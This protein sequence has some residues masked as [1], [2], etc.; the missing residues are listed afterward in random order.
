MFELLTIVIF[1]WLLV[2]AI[3]LAF[4]L[5]WGVA[6]I[7]AS[8]L[9]DLAFPV[10]IVCFIFV[11]AIALLVPVIMISIAAGILKAVV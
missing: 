11:G 4:K 9:I 2:K 7:A 5:T 8:I 1:I 3:G 10:L 6:K